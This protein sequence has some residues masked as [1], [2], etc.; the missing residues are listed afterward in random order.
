MQKFKEL[1]EALRWKS[2][3]WEVKDWDF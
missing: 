2:K 1:I 3:R